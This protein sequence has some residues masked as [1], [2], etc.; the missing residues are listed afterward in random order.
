M[1]VLTVVACIPFAQSVTQFVGLVLM[2]GLGASLIGTAPTAFVSDIT[3][4]RS[5][6]QALALLRSGTPTPSSLGRLAPSFS[7]SFSS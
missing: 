6:G 3:E 5:R 4:A 7:F 2:W 1:I